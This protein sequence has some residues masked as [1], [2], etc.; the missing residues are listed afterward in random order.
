MLN[1]RSSARSS[2]GRYWAAA[3]ISSLG[4]A[5]TDVALPVLVVQLLGASAAEYGVVRAAQ[6]VPYALLGL[7]VGVY[8]DRWRRRPTLVWSSVGRALSL[9][10]IVALWLSDALHIWTLALLLL[11]FGSFSVFGFA[12][13]QSLLPRLVPR[14]RLV[15][16]N[17]RLDRT[18]AA[19]QTLGPALGGGLVGLLGAPAAIAIDAVSY[20]VDAALNASVR[21]VEP[22]RARGERKLRAEIR[23]GLRFLYRH[24]VL[25][26]LALSTHI[27]F[28]A[29]G[30][31][32]T[33]LA[34]LVLRTLGFSAFGF[35]MLLT[36]LGITTLIGASIAPRLGVR[37]GSG[38]AVVVARALYPLAWILVAA[39]PPTPTGIVLLSVGI[40]LQG[41]SMGAEN[42]NELGLW[43]ILTPDGLL[44][45][46]NATRRSINRT[47]A[48]A[49]ALLAGVLVAAV[50]ERPVLGGAILVF[51]VAV[52]V[53]WRSPLWENPEA[54]GGREES[55]QSPPVA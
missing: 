53:A 45:R 11:L 17:S 50:G 26:P 7:V 33:V 15:L 42:A 1:E 21:V 9:G 47:M 48:A 10:A 44:G 13:E 16:A 22:R 20:L 4:T 27:W 31:A 29:N 41:L 3:A 51:A 34:L 40:A 14:D 8:V 30:A 52:L 28:I 25:A 46:A 55:T 6:L 54:R 5:I 49:G 12:A 35:S 36:V 19:A 38:R 37:L 32:M 23:D 43:Q 39:A 18:D 2:F 24:R